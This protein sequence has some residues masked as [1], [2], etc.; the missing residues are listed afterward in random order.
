M[1]TNHA[2]AGV[3]IV[4]NNLTFK[5]DRFDAKKTSVRHKFKQYTTKYYFVNIT[6][7]NGVVL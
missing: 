5:A 3:I 1:T 2:E 4:T 7:C 6:R